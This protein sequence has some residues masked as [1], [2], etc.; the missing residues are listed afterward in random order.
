MIHREGGAEV[1]RHG[2][3]VRA[4]AVTA[5]GRLVSGSYDATL[6]HHSG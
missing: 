5:Q 3:F 6:L 4:L 2:D 1:R